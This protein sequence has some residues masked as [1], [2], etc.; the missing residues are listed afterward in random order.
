[1][2]TALLH[3]VFHIAEPLFADI[4][5]HFGEDEFK[6]IVT[7]GSAIRVIRRR[8]G[9]ITMIGDIKGGSETM[10]TLF[11]S[12]A[13][14]TAQTA[15]IVLGAQDAGNDDGVKGNTFHRQ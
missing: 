15:H 2:E 9:V 1:M 12:I 6:G 4:T 3:L 7:N 5:K 10:T 14:D 11:G 13:V 8:N